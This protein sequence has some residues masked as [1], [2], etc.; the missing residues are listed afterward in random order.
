MVAPSRWGG[1][2]FHLLKWLN[3]KSD[4]LA[5]RALIAGFAVYEYISIQQSPFQATAKNKDICWINLLIASSLIRTIEKELAGDK[6][7]LSATEREKDGHAN[8][9]HIMVAPT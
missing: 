4:Q 9:G 8:N 1:N 3:H 6:E 7:H 5:K 2:V